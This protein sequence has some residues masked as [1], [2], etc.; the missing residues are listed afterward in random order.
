M[1]GMPKPGVSNSIRR[2]I[3]PKLI[4]NIIAKPDGK[5]SLLDYNFSARNIRHHNIPVFFY[6]ITFGDDI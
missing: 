4:K 3:K 6:K 5:S 2:R 1:P